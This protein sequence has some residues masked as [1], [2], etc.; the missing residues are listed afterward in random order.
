[1]TAAR[2]WGTLA[3]IAAIVMMV[4]TGL[5]AADKKH[6]FAKGRDRVKVAKHDESG[7]RETAHFWDVDFKVEKFKG[8]RK[9]G[10]KPY[11]VIHRKQNVLCTAGITRML[12]LLTG[13]G[14]QAYDATHARIGVG[15]GVTAATAADTDLAAAAGS[16]NR[17]F[18]LVDTT[19]S[20]STNVLTFHATFAT[21]DANFTWAE[22]CIDQGTAQGTTVTAP[23]LNRK[24]SALGTKTSASSFA[25]TVTITIT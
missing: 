11:A 8:D 13:A 22:F 4:C 24:V 19:P 25:I 17:L 20:I 15:N 14:G 12:N 10:Q 23:M 5:W 6:D 9:P 18:N 21:G 1:M 2:R 3:A 16:S 7:K